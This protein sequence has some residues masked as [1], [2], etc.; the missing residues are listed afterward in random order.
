MLFESNSDV[1][2]SRERSIPVRDS[3]DGGRI[4]PVLAEGRHAAFYVLKRYGASHPVSIVGQSGRHRRA[5]ALTLQNAERTGGLAPLRFRMQGD[6]GGLARLR[7][8]TRRG[9]E[10]GCTEG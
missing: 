6:T 2:Q 1:Y 5:R 10:G 7:F 4:M 3:L 9:P 8:R